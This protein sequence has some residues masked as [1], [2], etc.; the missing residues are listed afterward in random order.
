MGPEETAANCSAILD[1]LAAD[2]AEAEEA[3][4]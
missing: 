3:A 2:L 1:E 4:R